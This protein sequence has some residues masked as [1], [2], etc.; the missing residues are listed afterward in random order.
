MGRMNKQ[1]I[2][3]EFVF[4]STAKSRIKIISDRILASI[5]IDVEDIA[6]E[7]VICD[8]FNLKAKNEDFGFIA[9]RIQYLTTNKAYLKE[10]HERLVML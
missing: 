8:V 7:E 5:T 9:I 2:Y 10:K 4:P 3:R 6:K 1:K